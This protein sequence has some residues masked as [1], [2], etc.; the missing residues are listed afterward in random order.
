MW[1]IHKG[2]L[3]HVTLVKP[4]LTLKL[5]GMN[6]IQLKYQNHR[7]TFKATSTT[8]L[9]VLSFQ[10]LQKNAKTR[11]NLEASHIVPWKPDLNEQNDFKRVVLFRNGVT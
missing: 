4:N 5:D 11:I 10:M 9:H 6:I 3:V 1:I 2:D 7:N 8:V